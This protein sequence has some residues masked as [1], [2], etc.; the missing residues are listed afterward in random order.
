MFSITPRPLHPGKET[1]YPLYRKLGGC[2]ITA[3]LSDTDPRQTALHSSARQQAMAMFFQPFLHYR[4]E[5]PQNP[6][7]FLLA[8]LTAF[9]CTC[10]P[11]RETLDKFSGNLTCS[12]NNNIHLPAPV[13]I[14]LGQQSQA[15]HRN[16]RA[17]P[18]VTG[19]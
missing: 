18:C 12:A 8:C 19:Q 15:L 3:R 10:L 2:K 7:Y 14:Q 17:F 16:L 11:T 9:S 13:L 4:M 1:R 6:S 5:H